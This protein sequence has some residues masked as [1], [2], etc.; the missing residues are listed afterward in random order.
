MLTYYSK[1]LPN[2]SVTLHPLYQLLR[3]DVA[4]QWGTAE[5]RA[6]VA[7]K[8]LLTSSTCL[9]HFDSSLPLSLAC[10]ASSYG[11]G[12]VL[13]HQMPNGEE[14]PIAY[15]SRTLTPSEQNYSQLE[16][17]GLA[18]I[19][20]IKKFYDYVLGRTFDLV[21][22]HKPLLGLLQADRATS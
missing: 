9:T 1:F 14:R 21:T 19:F 17:E 18:C 10:N 7:S 4:W 3:K 8:E 6:F 22:D 12:A 16:K 5:A 11:L 20:G 15:A 13:S 2:L